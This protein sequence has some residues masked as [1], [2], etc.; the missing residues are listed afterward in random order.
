MSC[1][2]CGETIETGAGVFL[3]GYMLCDDCAAELKPCC[4]AE[5]E[6]D[7]DDDYEEPTP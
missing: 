1:A 2:C 5:N 7:A 3:S 6:P 4:L